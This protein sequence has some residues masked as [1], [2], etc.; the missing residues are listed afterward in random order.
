MR[1]GIFLGGV[2]LEFR[3]LRLVYFLGVGARDKV[4][5]IWGDN[6]VSEGV[7]VIILR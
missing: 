2:S 4:I 6:C 3:L 1:F 7:V 5:V